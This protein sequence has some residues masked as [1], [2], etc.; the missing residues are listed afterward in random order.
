MRG[1]AFHWLIRI[2]CLRLLHVHHLH[3]LLL[4]LHVLLH[5]LLLR[6]HRRLLI[7]RENVMRDGHVTGA[8]LV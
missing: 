7:L 6:H 1:L 4:L 2:L 5:L 8:A 3:L